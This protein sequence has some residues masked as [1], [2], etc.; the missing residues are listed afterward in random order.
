MRKKYNVTTTVL[1]ELTECYDI[2]ADSEEQA[3]ELL[4]LAFNNNVPKYES[5]QWTYTEEPHS[6]NIIKLKE[7]N[8]VEEYDN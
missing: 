8:S 2:I 6:G 5:V 4:Q 1:Y 7:I 3:K